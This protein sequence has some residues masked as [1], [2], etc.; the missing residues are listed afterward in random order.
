MSERVVRHRDAERTRA[1][2][3]AEATAAFAQTGYS[4]TTV[5]D[6]AQRSSTTKRMIYYYFGSKE[7]LYLAVLE[8]SYRE[9]REAEQ[10]L[11]VDGLE[12]VAALRQIAELTYDH[13]LEHR[14]F[15]RLVAV[16][17]IHYGRFVT[18]VDSLRELN[19]PALELLDDIL[20]R[21]HERALFRRDIDALDVHLLIS[22]YCVFQIANQHTFEYL[23]DTDL[24]SPGRRDHL[25]QMIGDVV[26]SWATAPTE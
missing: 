11:H 25:R 7:Q 5:D 17:N 10:R 12:P 3:L 15:V 26:V 14:D 4:G 9:I 6:I 8:N 18:Q 2:L 13:H 16:E 22:S 24:H 21:G 19:A 1:E 23:F 20:R